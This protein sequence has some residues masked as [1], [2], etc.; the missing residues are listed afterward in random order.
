MRILA[1][2]NQ[3]GGCGKTT[4]SINL[5][6]GLARR[7]FRTL[8]I[9]LDPQSHC[10]AGLG[11]PEDRLDLDISDALRTDPGRR[12]DR[13]RLVWRVGRGLDLVP[14]RMKLAGLEA[15]R[16][17][18][19]DMDQPQSRLASVIRRLAIQGE[20][21][22]ADTGDADQSGPIP[23]VPSRYD[24]VIIDCPPSIG[25]LSYNA[26]SA[27]DEVVIPVETSYFSLRGAGKQIQTA[28]SVARHVGASPRVRLLATMFDPDLPLARDL[29]DDLRDRFGAAVI[30]ETI[31]M[32]SNVK[33][34]ASFGRPVEE[35]APGSMGAADYA[36]LSEWII[37]HAGLERP[38]P[39]TNPE[40][41]ARPRLPDQTLEARPL[42]Q[43]APFPEPAPLSRAEEMA[44]KASAMTGTTGM[45]G[46]LPVRRSLMPHKPVAIE[47]T[48]QP[49]P[50]P[51][52]HA[53]APVPVTKD[54]AGLR[55]LWGVRT[56]E[57]GLLFV[58]PAAGVRSVA[59]VGDFNGWDP[60]HGGMT[61]RDDLGIFECRIACPPGR[62]HYRL[63][64]DGEWR[65]DPYNAERVPNGLGGENNLAV[66]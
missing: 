39:G 38:E 5:A 43:P 62:F 20:P 44:L 19:A 66:V 30:P 28:R 53:G 14:S 4:T 58:H 60:A 31:R 3:K 34:A 65:C 54:E 51:T 46:V 45:T 12:L 55:H 25:L 57:G 26:L 17:G 41:V 9:D 7:G 63:V 2:I 16:G 61:R 10:A 13:D 33:E 21:V 1:V 49:A 27:A 40:G 36:S 22:Q 35:H 6:S 59:V 18:L 24:A 8:L 11:V 32:D 52:Y 48:A 47:L 15:A 56:V 29:L 42:P 50:N 23:N 37:E 64:I